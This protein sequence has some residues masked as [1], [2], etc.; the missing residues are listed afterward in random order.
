MQVVLVEQFRYPYME[1]V[2]EAPAGKLERGEDP[3]EA[4]QRELR[5]ETGIDAPEEE[6][7]LLETGRE[8]CIHYD[9]YCLHREVPLNKIKLLPGEWRRRVSFC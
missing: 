7:H 2:L 6:F 1:D 3:F 4:A 5:E 9:Y 8:G